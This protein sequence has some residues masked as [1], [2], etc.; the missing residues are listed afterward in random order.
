VAYRP[1]EPSE[2]D[3]RH[4][5]VRAIARAS[6]L[7]AIAV[8]GVNQISENRGNGWL[9]Y[10]FGYRLEHRYGYG[11]ID[12]SDRS[13]LV[14]PEGMT[15]ALEGMDPSL[16]R[17]PS[18]HGRHPLGDEVATVLREWGIR[19]GAR[20]G[21]VG[22]A[23]MMPVADYLALSA[24]ELI[25]VAVVLEPARAVKSYAERLLVSDSNRIAEAGYASLAETVRPGVSVRAIGAELYRTVFAAG[26]GDHVMLTLHGSDG[27]CGPHFTAPGASD[28]VLQ[29]DDVFVFSMELTNSDGYWVELARVF[30]LGGL[31][32]D[33]ER[34]V[35]AGAEAM[36]TFERVA[37]PGATGGEVYRLV[38]DVIQASGFHQGHTPGHSL[39]QDVLEQPRI[40]PYDE[41]QLAEGMVIAFHPHV[42]DRDETMSAYQANVYVI[43]QAAAVPLSKVSLSPL[44]LS[45]SRERV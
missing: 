22:L 11:L 31:D 25:D 26:A 3:A 34:L 33:F 41:Q 43:D 21:V 1:I 38:D 8:L 29:S 14:F 45:G 2:R 23:E 17:V 12:L 9:S 44:M 42:L 10:L 40:A 32:S 28:Y 18:Y 13:T 30:A 16:Y 36:W 24:Y 37:V 20:I 4:G 35:E 5:R 6:G 7:D 15:W 19:D 39:G 27:R